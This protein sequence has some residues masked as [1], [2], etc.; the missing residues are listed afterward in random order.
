MEL[1]AGAEAGAE[2]A[3]ASAFLLF[4]DFL[5]EVASAD[6]AAAGAAIE[7][8]AGAAGAAIASAFLL[9]FFDDFLLEAISD[10]AA[11]LSVAAASAFL[12][13]FDF[14]LVVGVEV[15]SLAELVWDFAQPIV[16]QSA[17]KRHNDAHQVDRARF[18]FKVSPDF[19]SRG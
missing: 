1:A 18:F 2:A 3:I 16:T 4:L 5:L 12:A 6:G 9:F 13:F 15:W 10:D 17:R 7:F 19:I 8:A 11:E 14:L